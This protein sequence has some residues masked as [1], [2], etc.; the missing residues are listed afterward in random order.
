MRDINS[1]QSLFRRALVVDD[2]GSL[3]MLVRAIL[4]HTAFLVDVAPDGVQ[5][6]R[7][8]RESSYDAIICDI[9]M[10]NMDGITFFRALWDIN[11]VQARRVLFVTGADLD[12]ETRQ[13]VLETGQPIL[14]KPFEVVELQRIVEAVISGETAGE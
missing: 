6:C 9:C 13:K 14:Y 1:N 5:A 3:Q 2:E 12:P 10:P 8:V 7:R 11:P 4:E